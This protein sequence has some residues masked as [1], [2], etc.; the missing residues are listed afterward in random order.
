[1][2][3]GGATERSRT[4]CR[5]HGRPRRARDRVRHRIE[6]ARPR[7]F[8]RVVCGVGRTHRQRDGARAGPK[9]AVPGPIGR[10]RPCE[11]RPLHL[12]LAAVPPSVIRAD[13]THRRRAH[14]RPARGHGRGGCRVLPL[15][16]ATASLPLD[17]APAAAGRSRVRRIGG[18]R[19]GRRA[20]H[21]PSR[22]RRDNRGGGTG[23]TGP[24]RGGSGGTPSPTASHRRR[25]FRAC[26]RDAPHCR[27]GR[28][29]RNGR[30]HRRHR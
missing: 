3:T 4:R 2:V 8:H 25:R 24:V 11:L 6:V 13:G 29:A 15:G 27:G 9:A 20:P 28:G 16:R 26:R 30:D 18:D 1:M 5:G 22:R 12:S 7:R 21:T 19:C 14:R 17:P 10:H 23:H